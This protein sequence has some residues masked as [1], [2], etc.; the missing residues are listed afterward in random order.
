MFEAFKIKRNV[1]LEG[2]VFAKINPIGTKDE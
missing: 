1:V 2:G